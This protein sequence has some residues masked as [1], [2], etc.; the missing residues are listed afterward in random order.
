MMFDGSACVWIDFML[1]VCVRV[2]NWVG[3]LSFCFGRCE[4]VLCCAV[5]LMLI[6]HFVVEVG[7]GVHCTCY[8]QWFCTVVDFG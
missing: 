3:G 6:E 7:G 1:H 5:G 4:L 2:W 8:V